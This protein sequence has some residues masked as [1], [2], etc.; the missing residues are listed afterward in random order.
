VRLRCQGCVP[1]PP[2]V[3]LRCQGCV[4]PPPSVRL[5]CQGTAP[6]CQRCRAAPSRA[7][8]SQ[9]SAAGL[10]VVSRG[11]LSCQPRGVGGPRGTF[12]GTRCATES[13]LAATA[14]ASSAAFCPRIPPAPYPVSVGGA[15]SE[16][17]CHRAASLV[18]HGTSTPLD[19][20]PAPAT[21]GPPSW[22]RRP[23]TSPPPS[24]P[25]SPGLSVAGRRGFARA[26]PQGPVAARARRARRS[27]AAYPGRC[28]E[29]GPCPG[30]WMWMNGLCPGNVY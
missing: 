13:H 4:P 27:L 5:R 22:R 20:R 8:G 2:S 18:L 24:A 21:C 1:P 28:W 11:A 9:L 29:H 25:E 30:G 6:C 17:M 7:P 23:L 3:R 15:H 14:V 10:S 26:R 16:S 19:M 12:F